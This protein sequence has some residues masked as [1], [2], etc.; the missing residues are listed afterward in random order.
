MKKVYWIVLGV[1]TAFL[2]IGTFADLRIAE[3]VFN[4]GS[5]FGQFFSAAAMVPVWALVPIAAGLMFGYLITCFDRLSRLWRVIGLSLLAFGI[6]ISVGMTA[7]M[8][9]S[10]HLYGL[11]FNA[12]VYIVIALFLL[13]ASLG[14]YASREYPEAVFSAAVVGIVAVSGGRLLLEILKNTW[15]R[16]RFWTMDNPAAQFTAWYLPQFPDAAR[17]AEMGDYIK[18]FPSGH[19]LAAINVLW[20][21]MFPSFLGFC[22]KNEKAWTNCFAVFALCFWLPVMASRMILGEHF[23]SD[24]SLSAI[25]FIIVFFLINEFVGKFSPKIN[26]RNYFGNGG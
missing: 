1:V 15:G 25:A 13:T 4:P 17:I 19:S 23:L 24:V 14:A 26:R 22:R 8:Y 11:P 7:V 21:S 10:R 2:M 5:Q 16:Q 18:S 9:G 20:L 6:Y 3:T 12:L